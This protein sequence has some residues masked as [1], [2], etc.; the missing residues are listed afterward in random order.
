MKNTTNSTISESFVDVAKT[1]LVKGKKHYGALKGNKM[2]PKQVA[3]PVCATPV[4]SAGLWSMSIQHIK[5]LHNLYEV[6]VSGWIW[7]PEKRRVEQ[8]GDL[9]G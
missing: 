2:P 5:D 9:W 6:V 1:L 8:M 3:P 7:D 4:R